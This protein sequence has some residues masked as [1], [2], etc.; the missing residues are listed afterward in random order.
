MRFIRACLIAASC[1]LVFLG[2]AWA[3]SVTIGADAV[4]AGG[5]RSGNGNVL[6]AQIAKLAKAATIESLSFYVKAASGNLILGIY[7]ATGPGG[8]PGALKASTASF[9]PTKGWNTVNV[10]TPV[11]LAAGSYWLAFLPSSSA[12]VFLETHVTGNCKYYSYAFGG[13]PGNFSTSPASCNPTM[14]SFYATLTTASATAVNGACGSSNGG[15]ASSAPTANLCSAG[16]ASTVSGSGPW[17]W[18]CAGSGGGTTASCSALDPPPPV[19]GACGSAS[20]AS[21]STAPTANFCSA[22]TASSVSG[23]GPWSWNCAGGN[24]GS[25]ASCSDQLASSGS[26][27]TGSSGSDPTAGVLPSYNDAYANWKNAGLVTVGGI[28]NRTTQCGAT[29]TPSGGDDLSQITAAIAACPAGDVLQLGPGTFQITM[30]EYILLNKSITIRGTGTCNN[31]SSPYCQ[32]VIAVS[33]GMLPVYGGNRC[34]TLSALVTCNSNPVFYVAPQPMFVNTW[35]GCTFGVNCTGNSGTYA[36]AADA[37]QGQTT[38]QLVSTTGLSTGMWVRI[39]EASGAVSEAGP[40]GGTVFAAPDLTASGSPATGKIAYAGSGVEDGTLYGALHDRETSEIHLISSIGP[41]PC[42]GPGCTVTFDSPLTIAYR[43][44]GNHYAQVYAPNHAFLQEAGIENLTIT[45]ATQ[46]PIMMMFCAYCWAKGIETEMW[47]TGVVFNNSVRDELV[48]SYLN[49]CANCENNGAEYPLAIDGATTEML[50][51]N[52]II[53]LGGKGMVGR[54]S[55]G[56]NVVSYN[57]VDQTFY[58][59]DDIGNWWLD[60]SLNGSHYT[61]SHHTL[62]EGNWADNCDNDNTHGNVVYHTYFRNW[63]TGLRSNF[64]DPS[65]STPTSTT[66]NPADAAVS[67]VNGIAYAAGNSY[68]YPA[69]PLRPAGMM[70]LDY[71]MAFVGNVLGESGVTNAAHG[72]AYQISQQGA[73]GNHIWMLGWGGVSTQDANLTGAAGSYFFRHGNYDYYNNAIVD[74]V[75]GYSLTLPNS[76]YLTSQPAFFN[77]VATCTYTWPWVNPSGGTVVHTAS[78]GGSCT[79]YS[80]LPAKARY[81]AGTPF[82]QP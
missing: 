75:S 69:A 21:V 76:F 18:T 32:T 57:Y 62:F 58:E 17:T 9:A 59:A 37:A 53:T 39:D 81:D 77:T 29:L 3:Q 50:V 12:L 66:Y 38:I 40:A 31:A 71:W 42:P 60:M 1:I 49:N 63:C 35:T 30:S 41:G 65:L 4:W 61:G 36:L 25:T 78:G 19:N 51:T 48:D 54:A 2:S 27:S 11:S 43:Q 70:S 34:G 67:D 28:P 46:G 52:N 5:P 26:G 68:P 6:S 73:S 80:G 33:N 74:W 72:W 56:G 7:D 22:G 20:G 10:A 55:G 16:T 24:G 14:W 44:S 82:T 23:S 79:S 8:G 47:S 64:T 15:S 13:L 45:R